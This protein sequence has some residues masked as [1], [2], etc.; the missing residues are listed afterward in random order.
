[1]PELLDLFDIIDCLRE[2]QYL[3]LRGASLCLF[4]RLGYPT[5]L[6]FAKTSTDIN[7][8]I[9]LE[10]E[11]KVL[12]NKKE[13]VYFKNV[14]YIAPLFL[15]TLDNNFVIDDL[16]ERIVFLCIELNCFA[17][18]SEY[19]YY[20]T[21]ILKKAFNSKIIILFRNASSV[22]I[23]TGTNI[24]DQICISDWF[25]CSDNNLGDDYNFEKFEPLNR[26]HFQYL[27]NDSLLELFNNFSFE[28]SREYIK[29]PVSYE[30]IAYECFPCGSTGFSDEILGELMQKSQI[31]EHVID[32]LN[33]F[34]EQQG[35]DYFV[36]ENDLVILEEESDDLVLLEFDSDFIAQ[37]EYD[38]EDEITFDEYE[39]I[40][41]EKISI[42]ELNEELFDDPVKLLNWLEK[43]NKD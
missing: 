2:F 31:C 37:L 20:I 25:E 7:T 5:S 34:I 6:E 40:Q 13:T 22:A 4:R 10:T 42:D 43:I 21:K 16:T 1:M 39:N 3:D 9:Y 28:I 24:I 17:D 8:F 27:N 30:Y 26:I 15:L 29:Y 14:E 23:T 33:K 11:K 36:D 18:R 35:N 12:Y 41:Y 19:A 38:I 32:Y